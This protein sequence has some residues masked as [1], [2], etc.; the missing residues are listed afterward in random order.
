[1]DNRDLN[2]DLDKGKDKDKDKDKNLFKGSKILTSLWELP[3]LHSL[4]N[5]PAIII[6]PVIIVMI[7]IFSKLPVDISGLYE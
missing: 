4:T 5:I 3:F 6:S 2:L 7:I 1:M